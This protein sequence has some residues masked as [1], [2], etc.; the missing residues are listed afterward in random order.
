VAE[1]Y[2]C[3]KGSFRTCVC[4]YGATFAGSDPRAVAG[5]VACGKGR[6]AHVR[7]IIGPTFT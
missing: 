7:A 1:A 4:R 2:D 5:A 3:G 6:Y